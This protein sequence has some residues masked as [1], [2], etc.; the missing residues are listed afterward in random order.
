M[1]KNNKPR[2]AVKTLLLQYTSE[3]SQGGEFGLLPFRALRDYE[4]A[5]NVISQ[6][7]R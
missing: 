7:G 4:R 1:P 6:N 3:F 5:T 2:L